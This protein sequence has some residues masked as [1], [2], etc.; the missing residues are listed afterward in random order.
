AL[1]GGGFSLAALVVGSALFEYCLDRFGEVLG[2]QEGGVPG[3][4]VAQAFGDRGG[5]ALTQHVLHALNHQRRIGGDFAGGRVGGF[6]RRVLVG[7]DIVD[8]ADLLR[9]RGIDVLGRVGE[10]AQVA[11]ADD[12]GQALQRTHVGHDRDLGLAQAEFRLG[13]GVADIRGGNQVEAAAD[14]PA[15]D[16]GDHRFTA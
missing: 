7:V 1:S 3:G 16:G 10:F 8:Q 11:F 9:A 4:D 12:A 5:V 13:A 15:R 6:Q 2:G 14:A